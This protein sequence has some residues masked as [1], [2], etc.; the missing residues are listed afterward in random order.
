M[1]RK[2]PLERDAI[3]AE[4]IMKKRTWS[5]KIWLREFTY[6]NDSF[7]VNRTVVKLLK[8]TS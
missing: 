4:N 1:T 8:N 5:K 2:N 7:V 6:T 3:H